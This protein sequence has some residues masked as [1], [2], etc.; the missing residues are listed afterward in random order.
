MGAS[1][2]LLFGRHG[3]GTWGVGPTLGVGTYAF[4]DF[5]AQAGASV[6]VPVH[7]YLPIVLSAGGYERRVGGAWQ[8]GAFGTLFWGTR[9]FNYQSSYALAAGLQAEAR[10]GMGDDH[11]RT[12]ILSAHLDGEVLILPVLLI[13]NAF[14]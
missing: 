14:R 7:E 11:E 2:D 6:L 3:E 10:V 8:P 5:S 12:I 4:H 1:G 9:S 13:V